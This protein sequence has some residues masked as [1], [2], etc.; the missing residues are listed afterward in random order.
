VTPEEKLTAMNLPLP[1]APKPVGAYVPAA[2]AGNLVYTSGQLP[3]KDGDLVTRGHVAAEVP[4]EDAQAAARQA[5]LN[6]LAAVAG[7]I[8]SLSGIRRIVRL[9]GYIASSP[10]FAD[11][12]M[13]LN[14]ASDLLLEVFGERGRH[15][16]AAVGVAELPLGSPVEIELI[17]EVRA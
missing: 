10:G 4:L 3:T 14:P 16:R 11:Q 12:P 15:S 13:V 8:G 1:P 7:E 5:T 17:V 6:A 2:R 9:T